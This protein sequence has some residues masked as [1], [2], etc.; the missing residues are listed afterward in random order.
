MARTRQT[1]GKSTGGKT[2]KKQLVARKRRRKPPADSVV[3]GPDGAAISDLVALA[4][5]NDFAGGPYNVETVMH[6]I[7][8][9]KLLIDHGCSLGANNPINPTSA[10]PRIPVYRFLDLKEACNIPESRPYKG[11]LPVNGFETRLAPHASKYVMGK[12]LGY[13]KADQ[14]KREFLRMNEESKREWAG[15]CYA[16][17]EYC[18]QVMEKVEE[19]GMAIVHLVSQTKKN[20]KKISPSHSV[21][22]VVEEQSVLFFQPHFSGFHWP[23]PAVP[24]LA[25]LNDKFT[26]NL[27][28]ANGRQTTTHDCSY[29]CLDFIRSYT[30]LP[31]NAGF[32]RCQARKFDRAFINGEYPT[33]ARQKFAKF[34]DAAGYKTVWEAFD[35]AI[36]PMVLEKHASLEDPDDLSYESDTSLNY[37]SDEEPVEE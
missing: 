31:S 11:G 21:V 35:N 12:A 9:M 17:S 30:L 26:R 18:K 19:L 32:P 2:P 37:T 36:Q 1:A 20:G 5:S 4:A 14:A 22:V 34:Q 3:S 10:M 33:K 27:F 15:C 23:R 28:V 13:G 8:A 6:A 29:H 7:D 16:T 24:L 25:G